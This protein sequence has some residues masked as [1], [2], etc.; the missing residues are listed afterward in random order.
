MSEKLDAYLK[1]LDDYEA[2]EHTMLEL[3]RQ[4]SAVAAAVRNRTPPFSKATTTNWPTG[5][6]LQ[7]QYKNFIV[8]SN[9]C[10]SA[11]RDV[12][13][14]EKKRVDPPPFLARKIPD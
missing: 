11:W 7:R 8:A 4:L 12:P 5:D 3:D 14:G 2:A 1:S 6:D 10:E 13:E 9:A